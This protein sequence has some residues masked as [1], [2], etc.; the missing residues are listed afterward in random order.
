M[1]NLGIDQEALIKMFSE[2]TARQGEAV[3]NTVRDAILRALQGREL[4]LNNIREVLKNVTQAASAGA[5]RNGAA[6][7]DIEALLRRAFKG[8]D[9][10][11]LQAV[12]AHRKALEQL[13]A[14]GA[15]IEDKQMKALL[16]NLE[17]I[18]DTFFTAVTKATQRADNTLRAPWL[19]LLQ[20][21]KQEGTDTGGEATMALG[22][23][24]AQ[25]QKTMRDGRANGARA[26]QAMVNSYAALASGVLIGMSDGLQSDATPEPPS[27]RRH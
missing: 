10:A 20:S 4:T 15:Q 25:A 2:A 9:A 21:M 19:H 23:L 1:T 5:A 6:P 27:S 24:L 26:V 17:L 12:L 8:M 18:E 22:Q 13:V 7:L 11:L 3:A 16:A 14:Q